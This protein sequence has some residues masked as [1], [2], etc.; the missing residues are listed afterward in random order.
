MITDMDL[1]CMYGT[2]IKP[3]EIKEP[4]MIIETG[5]TY[6][7]DEDGSKYCN[8]MAFH[9]AWRTLK[10]IFGFE[11]F[12][13]TSIESCAPAGYFIFTATN[14]AGGE[15][16][17]IL[18]PRE[19]ILLKEVIDVEDPTDLLCKPVSIRRPFDN[20]IC[21]WVTDQWIEDGIELLNVVHAG[22]FSVVPR[23]MATRIY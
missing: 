6:Q 9:E 19:S 4:K 23:T 11:P 21:G 12:T 1:A 22:S 7:L 2:L 5:K 3:L 16:E 18:Y 20:P 13:V 8:G 10:N 15:L 14:A 17:S